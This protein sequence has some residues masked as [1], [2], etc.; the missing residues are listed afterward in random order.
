MVEWNLPQKTCFEWHQ[1][2]TMV[3]LTLELER[4]MLYYICSNSLLAFLV[5]TYTGWWFQT[6]FIFH[7]IW[8][9]PSHWLIF[10]RGVETTNQF[11]TWWFF[12]YPISIN[13]PFGVLGATSPSG[14]VFPRSSAAGRAA[15]KWRLLDGGLRALAQSGGH[16]TSLCGLVWGW[17]GDRMG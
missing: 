9:N 15:P 5:A 7:N 8:D 16:D 4:G 14:W 1:R 2:C 17:G 10:F 6:F 11:T 12:I 13:F 3:P